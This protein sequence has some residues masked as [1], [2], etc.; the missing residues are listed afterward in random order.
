LQILILN[1][2][3]YLDR[4]CSKKFTN[5]TKLT[6]LSKAYK[7]HKAKLFISG[8]AKKIICGTTESYTKKKNMEAYFI[9]H[10]KPAPAID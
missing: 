5:L 2:S 4:G 8:D 6:K 10:I 3:I 9:E 1:S 7:A